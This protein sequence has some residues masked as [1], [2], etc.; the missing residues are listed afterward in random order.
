VD[1]LLINTM[2]EYARPGA[3]IPAYINRLLQMKDENGVLASRSVC[4]YDMMQEQLDCFQA[5]EKASFRWNL[6]YQKAI[7]AV[8]ERYSDFHLRPLIYRSDDDVMDAVTDEETDAGFY[9]ILTGESLKSGNRDGIFN[10]VLR[11]ETLMTTEKNFRIPVMLA[12]KPEGSA[13]Y[14]DDNLAI[15]DVKHKARGI[16]LCDMRLNSSG[17]RFAKPLTEESLINYE[18][19]GI[20]KTSDWTRRWTLRHRNDGDNW[21]SLDYSKYDSTLPSWLIED[22][23]RVLEKAFYLTTEELSLLRAHCR[24]FIHKDFVT[25]DGILHIHHGTPSG[26]PFTSIING[27]CNEIMTETW[28]RA[29]R[30]HVTA[31]NIMGDDNLIFVRD[32]DPKVLRLQV[33]SYLMHNFGV[34][35]NGTKSK[36][37]TSREDVHYLSRYWTGTGVWRAPGQ[38]IFNMMFPRYRRPYESEETLTPEII[39]YSIYLVYDKAMKQMFDM[40]RFLYDTKL[41]MDKIRWTK[42]L[43]KAVPYSLRQ[44]IE[45]RG[46]AA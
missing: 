44:E 19:S 24:A 15:K 35:V 2:L 37:G 13:G 1:K 29:L 6:N 14:D 11:I 38:I 12:M 20:G 4:S 46:M 39:M 27:I 42:E 34:K 36:T 40:G 21:V 22:A 5:P 28:L 7:A 17:R 23:F 41:S 18:Y 26:S 16:N 8:M 33:A 3:D 30:V 9:G 25:P 43:R 10:E 31:Y 45:A 32:V